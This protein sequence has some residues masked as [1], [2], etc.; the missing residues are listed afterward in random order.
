MCE[1]TLNNTARKICVGVITAPHGV[2]GLIRVKSFTEKQ[3][4]I[5]LYAPFT[6]KL[7]E[8]EIRIEFVGRSKGLILARVDGVDDRQS[9]E[10][11]RGIELFIERG[12]LPYAKED[13]EYY[14][15]DLVGLSVY[16]SDGSAYG[17]VKAIHN[18]GAGD[19]IDIALISH[20]DILL[21]FTKDL[22][23]E[24][25]LDSGRLIVDPP[26]VYGDKE[27]N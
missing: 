3:E 21:P 16:L 4:D 5:L 26:R 8:R 15:A 22:V 23:P 11:L 12:V 7:G 25:D 18:F 9:A 13:D 6:D 27:P 17:K 14:Y 1:A 19:M 24:V 10:T 20:G 2:K